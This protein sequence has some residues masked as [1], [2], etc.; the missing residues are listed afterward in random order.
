MEYVIVYDTSIIAVNCGKQENESSNIVYRDRHGALHSIDFDA[1]AENFKSEHETASDHCIGDRSPDECCFI[2]YTSGIKTKVVFQ[3]RYV[4]N[5]SH[6]R[7]FGGSKSSRFLEL[8]NLINRTKYTTR[9]L[10]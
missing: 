2:F 6:Y 5:I 1:C 7:R 9:D 4:F 10:L 3:K 8:H